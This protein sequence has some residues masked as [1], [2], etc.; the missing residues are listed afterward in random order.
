MKRLL[1]TALLTALI[2]LA[3][4]A[5]RPDSTKVR[6]HATD[7]LTFSD[8]YLDSVKVSKKVFV[9]DYTLIGVDY[10]VTMAGFSCNPTISDSAPL[11]VPGYFSLMYTHYEKLF[12]RYANF[13]FRAGIAY[14]HEG[15]AF[16]QNVDEDGTIRSNSVDGATKAVIEL[17]EVPLLAGFHVDASPVK[18]QAE[19]G[20]YGAYRRSIQREG[21]TLE[22]QFRTSFKEYERRF[23]YGLRGGAGIAFM[24]DPIEIHFNALIRWGWQSLYDPDYYSKYYYRFAYPLDLTFTA[25]IHFQFTKRTGKTTR[26]LKQMAKEKV[27]GKTENSEGTDR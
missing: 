15:F 1:C 25:G 27:Y 11:F 19:V 21:P 9:N 17:L 26:M 14:A 2:P 4:Y 6:R 8:D 23:D 12:E 18:F 3:T 10:G 5:S 24:L 20:V 22:E 16:N 7:T 13:A